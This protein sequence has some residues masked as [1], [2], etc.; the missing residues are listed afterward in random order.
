MPQIGGEDG[1][2]WWGAC[3]RG[4]PLNHR[5]R[6]SILVEG[7]GNGRLLVDTGPDLRTQLLAC[8]VAGVDAIL[9]THD[10]ADHVMGLDEVRILNRIV[11]RPLE[12]F[13][14]E[15]TLSILK[16]RFDYAFLPSTGPV[17]Y[18]PAV[19]A[20][21]LQPGDA[22]AIAGHQVQTFRQDHAV[23]ETL[24]LRIGGFAYCTDL[25]RLPEESLALLHG[26]DT[27]VVGCFQRRPHK[28]HAN[29]D[30]VLEWVEMLRPRRTVLTHM[31]PDLDHGWMTANLPPGVE[32]GYDGMV[33]TL[34]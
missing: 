2:G 29:L 24:G 13:G 19:D 9:F 14:T 25:V 1:S 21:R 11:G 6:S 28:V 22:V 33:L 30:Q 16:Q 3:D 20:V 18:R 12:A 17:F 8:R 27:W 31:S 4:N 7:D 10:H 34:T 23:M 5:T 15:R 32:P 26:L